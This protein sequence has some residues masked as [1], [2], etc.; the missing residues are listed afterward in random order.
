MI[1][2]GDGK[3][4]HPTQALLDLYTLRRRAGSLDGL[5]VWI[6]GDVL[7][8]RVARSNILAFGRMG[9]AR[10]GVRPADA[11]P[12]RRR[13]ARLRGRATTL[14]EL[15]E[16]D[17]VYA[18]RMQHERMNGLA[19]SRRCASTPPATRSTAAGSG[20]ASC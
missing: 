4:E 15:G 18:L 11:D 7:H 19:S 2:A 17:V 1:N 9:C 5:H 14:D 13:G 6:V 16:A 12:A 20:R 8:S 10:H 3:H